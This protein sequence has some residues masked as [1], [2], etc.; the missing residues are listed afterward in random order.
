MTSQ[1]EAIQ[2]QSI[3]PVRSV[4]RLL[5]LLVLAQ[6]NEHSEF[7]SGTT[8]T[9]LISCLIELVRVFSQMTLLSP[10]VLWAA[11]QH[12]HIILKGTHFFETESALIN[13][14]PSGNPCFQ[15]S[16]QCLFVWPLL[17][18]ENITCIS[19]FWNVVPIMS[20]HQLQYLL[21]E[22]YMWP[23]KNLGKLQK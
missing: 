9:P 3:F 16:T 1:Q 7:L 15:R 14:G 2:R 17:D 4:D 12:P 20:P 18:F 6:L 8:V 23:T 19:S 21:P 11:F 10:M 13:D 22:I 5:L